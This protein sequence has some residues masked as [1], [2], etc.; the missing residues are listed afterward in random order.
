MNWNN[1][2]N[3]KYN[4]N[5]MENVSYDII[6]KNNDREKINIDEI[7]GL[8]NNNS[9]TNAD[10]NMDTIVASEIDY[11]NNYNNKSLGKILDFYGIC[12]RK[13]RKDEMVQSIILFEMELCNYELVEERKRLW[14]NF[15]ELKEH[16]FFNKFMILEL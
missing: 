8:V 11:C 16:S 5:V 1:I 4:N 15:Q 3:R 6:E 10:M 13:L 9:I 2:L 14:L 7:I 12:K